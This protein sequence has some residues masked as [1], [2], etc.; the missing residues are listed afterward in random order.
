MKELILSAV[1]REFILKAI[2]E[3]KRLD[4]RQAYDVR[5]MNIR[6]GVDSGCCIVDLGE[7]KVMCDST[8]SHETCLPNTVPRLPTSRTR[9]RRCCKNVAWGKI[10][11]MAVKEYLFPFSDRR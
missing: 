3:R 9:H 5:R 2:G 11:E 8:P 4:G 7:T 10:F 6:F 1:E